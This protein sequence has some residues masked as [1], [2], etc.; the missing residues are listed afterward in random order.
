MS[1]LK[2]VGERPL[3]V[4]PM[5]HLDAAVARARAVGASVFALSYQIADEPLTTVSYPAAQAFAMWFSGQAFDQIN[6]L[7]GG[8]TFVIEPQE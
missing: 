1:K 8:P 4:T 5:D 2:V 6:D 3:P 7:T